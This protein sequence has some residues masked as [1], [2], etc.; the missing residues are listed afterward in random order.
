MAA[1]FGITE[2]FGLSLTGSGHVHQSSKSASVEVATMKD[3]TGAIRYAGPKKL[4]TTTVSIS[5]KGAPDL[6]LVSDTLEIGAGTMFV[7]SVKVSE[8][9]DD[10]PDF[11]IEGTIYSNVGNS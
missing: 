3:E 2:T 5:G 9:N 1:S 4:V 7:S 8:S 10:F 6:N 11:Q